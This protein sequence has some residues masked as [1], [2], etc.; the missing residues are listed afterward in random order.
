MIVSSS[1]AKAAFQR[2]VASR[3]GLVPNFFA[4]APDAPEIIER[5]WAFAK[6]GY[7]DNPIPSLFKERLFVYLS[8]FCEV[9]YC[10]ARHC[11]FLV[12]RGHSSGDPSVAVQSIEQ[13]IKLLKTPPPWDRDHTLIVG[14]L[15][16]L[17]SLMEW[18]A[19]DTEA[20]D[21]L[22]AAA[23]LLFVQP[24]RAHRARRALHKALGGNR[25]EHLM[26]LLAF[27]RTAHYWTVLH[28]EL[29]FEDDVRDLLKVNE[30]LARLLLEDQEAA[31][32]DMGVRLFEE[33]AE[34]RELNERH[35]LET[36]K[37]ALEAQVQQKELLLKE[38]NHRVKNSLQIVSSILQLQ[39]PHVKGTEA[40]DAMRDTAAQVLAIAAVHERLYTGDDPTVVRLDIFLSDLC[41]DIGRAYG[42]ADGIET[43]VERIEVPTDI[44]IPLA[45]IVNELVTNVVKHVGPPCRLTLR[46]KTGDKLQLVISEKGRRFD[47][48]M[49][50]SGDGDWHSVR[51]VGSNVG[52]MILAARSLQSA[53]ARSREKASR[54][55]A[56]SDRHPRWRGTIPFSFQRIGLLGAPTSRSFDWGRIRHYV[57]LRDQR[58]APPSRNRSRCEI[59]DQPEVARTS[60]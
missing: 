21:W 8:R 32:C 14:G 6:A 30:E 36:A 18:P 1:D 2:E 40:A 25:F 26:G 59:F 45:L 38:V 19:P 47:G 55:R 17:P 51:L 31:R 56:S 13:A 27:I 11:A 42:C 23:T 60:V 12:G 57:P 44:A 54:S 43:D 24:G 35:E 29:S 28:P 20:E 16:A 5:L 37:R 41:Q 46:G 48:V 53:H 22:I 10:I 9:R 34:L 52:S 3:F 4:S 58:G 50:S 39:I 7:L 33:L 49:N 15:E